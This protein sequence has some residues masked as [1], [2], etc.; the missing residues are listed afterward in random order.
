MLGSSVSGI[1][2]LL[3]KDLLKLVFIAIVVATPIAWMAMNNWLQNFDL[4]NRVTISW[5]I[6]AI[7]GFLAIVIAFFTVSFKAIKAALANPISSLR[8]E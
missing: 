7:A 1:V 3:A 8:T 6:F 4:P 5:W 2:M